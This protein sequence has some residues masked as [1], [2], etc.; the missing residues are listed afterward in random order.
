MDSAVLLCAGIPSSSSTYLSARQKAGNRIK[1]FRFWGY[2]EPHQWARMAILEY[3][4]AKSCSPMVM[5]PRE[6]PNVAGTPLL[7]LQI[8]CKVQ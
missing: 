4:E 8:Q 7:G 1:I 6:A 5:V 3:P 2:V